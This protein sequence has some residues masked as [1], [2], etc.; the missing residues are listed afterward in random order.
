[1]ETR[2]A[3][4]RLVIWPIGFAI[5]S[6][7][8]AILVWISFGG[9]LP[10][11]PTNYH[12]TVP[13]PDA[14]NIYP[15]SAVEIAGVKIGKVDSVQRAGN[16]ARLRIE[17]Q[18]RYVP[19]REGATAIARTKTLLGE[20]YLELAPGPRNAPAIPDGG[21]LPASHVLRPQ[22]LDQ[23]L[24]TFAP[25]TR[26]NI[27]QL[28][29]G[30]AAAVGDRSSDISNDLGS[31]A[32]TFASLASVAQSLDAQRPAL[33]QLIANSGQV[34]SAI[35]DRQGV[36]QAAVTAGSQLFDATARRNQALAA[37][38]EALPPFLAQLKSTSNTLAAAAPDL[39]AA[40]S[41]L[42]PDAPQ[43]AP[44]LSSIDQAAPRFRV[45]FGQ[46]PS[47]IAAGDRG[48]PALKRILRAAGSAFTQ[49]YPAARQLIPLLQLLAVNRAN[50]VAF[51]ANV[52]N[53]A[54]ITVIGSGGLSQRG[55]AAVPTFWNETISGWVKRLPTNRMNPYP[56]PGSALDIAH[57]GLRAFDCR[58]IHNPLYLPPTGT[59]AP[60]CL[61]QGPWTFNGKT[62]YYP[63]LTLAS[64]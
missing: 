8:V 55:F 29:A 33:Q 23:F 40:V 28:F 64:P 57:G 19:L 16:R 21:Q 11:G 38:I 50:A 36:V 24:E 31:A 34:L 9:S 27:R 2:T 6:I 12:V 58:N 30:L 15:G 60:P 44:A 53:L 10:F 45:L 63:R 48:L 42:E 51:A 22:Q 20:G 62:A 41:A 39:Q 18:P 17:F 47:V 13:M 3:N 35:G 14:T 61:T 26:Q 32:P 25:S 46:L 52:A 59:G 49:I 43:L 5:A 56:A 37:T 1:M 54:N 7:L 4:L